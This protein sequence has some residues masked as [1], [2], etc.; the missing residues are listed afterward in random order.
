V[1][2]VFYG[3]ISF[4]FQYYGE[5][6]TYLGM[7]SPIAIMSVVSW[8]RHPY[9]E[10][11]EVE[12]NKVKK[13]QVA[14][15]ILLT[16]LVTLGFYFILKA[17]DTTNL[18]FSTLSVTTSFLAS[19]LTFMRSPFYALAY[20][21]NDIVLFCRNDYIDVMEQAVKDGRVSEADIDKSVERVLKLKEKLG[22]FKG[23]EIAPT[24][25]EEEKADFDL[26]NYKIAEKGLTLITNSDNIIPFDAAKAKNAAIIT[27][28]T[29]PRFSNS[30]EAMVD[31]FGENGI[32]AKI[33]DGLKSQEELEEISAENDIIVYAC[34]LK[35]GYKGLQ[36]FSRPEDFDTLFN[37][38][39]KLL[40]IPSVLFN[41]TF[42]T[43]FKPPFTY[44]NRDT[45]Q[46]AVSHLMLLV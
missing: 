15:M 34:F 42:E 18:L 30:L 25:T 40:C 11:K 35:A 33:Y 2:A 22:L 21:G 13:S 3:I 27:I 44:K 6:I 14:M 36:F 23:V 17:L 46:E 31:A 4:Y 10:T 32:S 8:I 9:K 7:T 1:F 28:S 26:V 45:A 43:H 24:L 37:S 39:Y 20:A 38:I 5:V 19:Y 41:L 29:D 12:V 16:L